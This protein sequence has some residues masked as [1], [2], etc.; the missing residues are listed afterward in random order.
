MDFKSMGYYL[1]PYFEVTLTLGCYLDKTSVLN[2]TWL[3]C[4]EIIDAAH[5]YHK[6]YYPCR[7]YPMLNYVT[8]LLTF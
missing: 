5:Q 2:Q 3:N 8:G 7:A 4:A 6:I 1:K